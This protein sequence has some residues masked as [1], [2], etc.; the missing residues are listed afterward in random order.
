M[1]EESKVMIPK[2]LSTSTICLEVVDDNGKPIHQGEQKF[3]EEGKKREM[4]QDLP[5]SRK[6]K[7]ENHI[8]WG[9]VVEILFDRDIGFDC[10]PT[11]GEYP[12]GLGNLVEIC[13][14]SVDELFFRRQ[15]LECLAANQ[16]ESATKSAL[17]SKKRKKTSKKSSGN[18]RKTSFE[19]HSDHTNNESI[20]LEEM[21]LEELKQ[22]V[23]AQVIEEADRIQKLS[24]LAFSNYSSSH[25]DT[26]V[27]PTALENVNH[28]I[29]GI[30]NSREHIGCSCKLVKV[31]KLKV[32]QLKTKL[33]QFESQLPP[34]TGSID[35]MK[36]TDLMSLVKMFVKDCNQCIDNN[37][38]CVRLEVPC[39]FLACECM[40]DSAQDCH[41]S[42]GKNSF[43]VDRI[44]SMRKQVLAEWKIRNFVEPSKNPSADEART[45][46]EVPNTA[47][48][49]SRRK[50]TE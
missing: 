28:E 2:V 18:Q 27:S 3:R 37:C 26:S 14:S 36:K 19:H 9:N 31:D 13:T 5:S 1:S 24:T 35:K 30:R 17:V 38:E 42:F 50:H 12:L 7:N 48:R 32:N 40:E 44:D 15:Y 22:L 43:D 49:S 8:S 6:E 47:T 33:H 10:I 21:N 46:S 29:V 23:E 20:A 4:G 11:N 25:N 16:A 41:N 34:N 45:A 39:A